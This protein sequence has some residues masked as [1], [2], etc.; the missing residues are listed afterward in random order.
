MA[1]GDYDDGINYMSDVEFHW[2]HWR[3]GMWMMITEAMITKVMIGR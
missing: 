2:D 3:I 1:Y